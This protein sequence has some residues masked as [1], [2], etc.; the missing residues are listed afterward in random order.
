[1]LV[2]VVVTHSV[3]AHVLDRCLRALVTDGAVDRVALVDTGGAAVVADDLIP[4]VDVIA[5]ENRGYGAAANVGFAWARER[6]AQYV[7]L[8]ND[9]AVPRPAWLTALLPEVDGDVGA[10]Q[11]ALV[12]ADG[13]VAS[14]GVELDP[15]GAGHDLGDG[16]PFEPA[17]PSDLEIFTG[18][19]VV[20]SEAFLRSTGGFDERYFL[21]YEDVDLARRGARLGWRY[22][23]VPA[24]VVEHDRGT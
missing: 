9:D 5:L 4:D 6:G 8:L 24:S 1:M 11:P 17:P 23:V 14:M 22:R 10:A 15:H 12:S 18:G 3:G 16:E 21:Y 2:A 19:A 13:L 7:A 20:F